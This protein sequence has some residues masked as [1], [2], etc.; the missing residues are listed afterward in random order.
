MWPDTCSFRQKV[1]SYE[2]MR[3]FVMSSKLSKIYTLKQTNK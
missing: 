2:L 3:R 1:V